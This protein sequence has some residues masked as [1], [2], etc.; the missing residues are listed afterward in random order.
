M[1]EIRAAKHF[2]SGEP[3]IYAGVDEITYHAFDACSNS[4][5][6]KISSKSPAHL[7]YELDAPGSDDTP[8]KKLGRAI[9]SCILE[10]DLFKIHYGK[11]EGDRRTKAG[12][13]AWSEIC[14]QF[15]EDHVIRSSEFDVCEGIMSSISGHPV[16]GPLFQEEAHRELTVLWKWNDLLCK[17]RIDFYPKRLRFNTDVK[18]ARDGEPGAFSKAVAIRGYHRQAGLYRAACEY[19]GLP[20]RATLFLAVEKDPPYVV[21]LYEL[22]EESVDDGWHEA[23]PL[24]ETYAECVETGRWPGYSDEVVTISIPT[25]KRNQIYEPYEL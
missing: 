9:H 15:G 3:G 24:F 11:F 10:P 8:A 14:D 17:S 22:D 6:S 25:W 5:L 1:N 20:L 23:Q 12:K 13:E 4:R 19:V 18:S 7:R 16:A 21:C 2:A